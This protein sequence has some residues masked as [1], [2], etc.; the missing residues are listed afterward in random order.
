MKDEDVEDGSGDDGM[1]VEEDSVT[2][3]RM[4][5]ASSDS[6]DDQHSDDGRLEDVNKCFFCENASDRLISFGT[7]MSC[8][9]CMQLE[10]LKSDKARESIKIPTGS[11]ANN[12]NE[13]VSV[14]SDDS[15]EEALAKA[16]D[17]A[18]ESVEGADADLPRDSLSSTDPS[19]PPRALTSSNE[20]F[21][22]LL[23]TLSGRP[24]RFDAETVF[25]EPITYKKFEPFDSI[26]PLD[27]KR[28][29]YYRNELVW[30]YTFAA[31]FV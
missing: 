7:F 14:Y 20:A 5:G 23:K 10:M 4:S 27:V 24:F 1:E 19:L 17:D 29:M 13:D 30:F 28:W 26:Q 6:D 22:N 12:E 9:G 16:E 2:V 15:E 31:V 25:Q 11:S 3:Y 18:I 8:K 21:Q